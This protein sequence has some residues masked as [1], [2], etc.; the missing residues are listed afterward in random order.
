MNSYGREPGQRQPLDRYTVAWR[1]ATPKAR[2]IGLATIV[3]VSILVAGTLAAVTDADRLQEV[4]ITLVVLAVVT[5]LT[6]AV[7]ARRN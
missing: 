5:V 1:Q 4:A 6:S 2:R 7:L 3:A